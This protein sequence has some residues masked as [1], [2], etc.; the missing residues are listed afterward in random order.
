[1]KLYV[2]F[3]CPIC[4]KMLKVFRNIE[5]TLSGYSS[6]KHTHTCVCMCVQA[7]SQANGAPSPGEEQ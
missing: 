2:V 6:A 5:E 3:V 1:M 4:V 7:H